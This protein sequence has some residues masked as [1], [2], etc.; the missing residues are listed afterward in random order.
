MRA[1]DKRQKFYKGKR[2]WK[3]E[4]IFKGTR[5]EKEIEDEEE[6]VKHL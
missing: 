2:D 6:T 5:K 3:E 4:K 1:L